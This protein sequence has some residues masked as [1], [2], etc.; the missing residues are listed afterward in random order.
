MNLLQDMTTWR[1]WRHFLTG[2]FFCLGAV[3]TVQQIGT[4]ISKD[5]VIFSGYP[6]LALTLT[7]AILGSLYW[8]WPRPIEQTYNT[9]N[10]K[11]SII[12]GNILTESTHLVIGTNDTFDMETPIIIANGSLQGQA[13]A[14]LYG[15]D[16][17]RLKADI[18]SALVAKPI[19]GTIAKNGNVNQY[20]IG[21]IATV[22]HAAR[23]LFFLAYCEMNSN[24]EAS[25]SPD[26]IWKSLG[27]LWSEVSRT[28]NGGTISVPVIGGGQARLSN[29]LPAQDAI[30]FTILSFILASRQSRV[31]EELR[32]I[33]RPEDYK[34]LDRLELQAFLSSLRSS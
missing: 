14:I 7:I 34:K 13:L 10:I 4:A 33:V 30:R 5:I 3:S 25:S 8:S 9:P 20:G 22:N 16:I 2:F 29:I 19:I 6:F 28:S 32:I 27:C 21:A 1:F 23:L 12:K 31:C 11:I 17:N 26:K 24:N 15:N 18:D